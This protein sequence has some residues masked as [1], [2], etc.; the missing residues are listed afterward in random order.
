[1]RR[2]IGEHGKEMKSIIGATPDKPEEEG[3]DALTNERI[4]AK[5]GE[6]QG[7]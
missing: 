7:G 2:W 6:R 3:V 4:S 1:M 5:G